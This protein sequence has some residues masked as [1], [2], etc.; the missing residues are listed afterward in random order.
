MA[1]PWLVVLQ[2]VPW[3]DVIRNAPK[4][5]DGAKKLWNAI[6]R[7][8]VDP[9]N[10]GQMEDAVPS[11]EDQVIATLQLR[12]SRLETAT[13]ELHEQM[14]ASSE[15]IKALAEQNDQLVKRIEKNRIQVLWM[16]AAISIL[17]I[18][19]GYSLVFAA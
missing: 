2:N 7:K 15:L 14:L 4:V 13:T 19:T 16:L 5:A 9:E 3:T 8:A 18:V 17:A 6:G 11:P 1:F 10:T 12:I